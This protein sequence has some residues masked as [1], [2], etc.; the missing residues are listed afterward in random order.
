MHGTEVLSILKSFTAS[1]LHSSGVPDLCMNANLFW[2]VFLGCFK[3]ANH[4]VF[5]HDEIDKHPNVPFTSYHVVPVFFPKSALCHWWDLNF[6]R[7]DEHREA[8]KTPEHFGELIMPTTSGCTNFCDVR[9]YQN[10]A[11]FTTTICL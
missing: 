9:K 8:A 6:H 3:E 4:I 1:N 5:D 7:L 10:G 11:G 2:D